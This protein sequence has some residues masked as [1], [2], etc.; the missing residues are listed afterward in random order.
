MFLLCLSKKSESPRYLLF[1]FV[2][3]CRGFVGSTGVEF[4]AHTNCQ[5]KHFSVMK[6]K[7]R[8]D[9]S[10]KMNTTGG[11]KSNCCR[12]NEQPVSGVELE[13]L[14][15]A[16]RPPPHPPA[17]PR[18]LLDTIKN[19]HNIFLSQGVWALL[20]N[21]KYTSPPLEVYSPYCH[22]VVVY[23]LGINQPSLPTHFLFYFFG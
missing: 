7:Y 2:L 15:K 19:Y 10:L 21:G 4:L 3:S 1:V 20:A 17:D 18:R 11:I 6:Q 13:Q 14:N 23:V 16:R 9:I 12:A 5:I 8:V 22:N